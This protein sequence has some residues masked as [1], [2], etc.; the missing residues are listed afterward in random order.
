MTRVAYVI[1]SFPVRSETFV[2]REVMGLRERGLEI[3]VFCV[4]RPTPAQAGNAFEA[5][6]GLRIEYISRPRALASLAHWPARRVTEFNALLQREATLKSKSWLRLGRALAIASCLRQGGYQ[7]IHSHWPYGHQLAALAH[8]I[9]GIPSSISVHAHEVAHDNGHFPSVFELIDFAAFCNDAARTFLLERVPR[10][11]A[12]KCHLVYHGVDL[13]AFPQLEPPPGSEFLRVVSAGRLTPTK[14]FPRLLRAVAQLSQR[15]VPVTLTIVGDGSQREA[16]LALASELGISDRLHL[17]GWLE[18]Q[19]L[20]RTFEASDVFCL[21]PDTT[22]HDGLP[23]VVLEA[24]ALGRPVVLSRLPAAAEAVTN[25]VDGFVVEP[26]DTE[27]TCGALM[28]L[29]RDPALRQQMATAA[30]YRVERQHDAHR[31]L[32][33]LHQLLLSKSGRVS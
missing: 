3:D 31:H 18:P 9:T 6:R 12:D 30:R 15:G 20:R 13:T 2:Y 28:Q 4:A 8:L 25:G 27:A 7:R 1:G 29:A 19:A 17:T 33:R 11:N 22:F 5:T 10:S 16:L 24:Q 14:G 23:N 26:D 21:L 32:E